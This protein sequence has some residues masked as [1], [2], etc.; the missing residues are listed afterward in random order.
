MKDFDD[1][2]NG[3]MGHCPRNCRLDY[4]SD[5][6]SGSLSGS[7]VVFYPC[8]WT[9]GHSDTNGINKIRFV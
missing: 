5:P 6:D 8:G 9:E 4:G 7:R 3:A 1:F 2:L